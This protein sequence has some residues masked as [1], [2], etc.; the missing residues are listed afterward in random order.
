MAQGINTSPDDRL[1]GRMP[2]ED[3]HVGRY[4]GVFVAATLMGPIGA[5]SAAAQRDAA[6]LAFVAEL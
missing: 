4:G 1:I 3:G 6:D 5:L 2:D